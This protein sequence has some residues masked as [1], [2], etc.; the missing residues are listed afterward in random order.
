MLR[1]LIHARMAWQWDFEADPKRLPRIMRYVESD[2]C[3]RASVCYAGVDLTAVRFRLACVCSLN[4]KD[5]IVSAM[6]TKWRKLIHSAATFENRVATGRS[7]PQ[8]HE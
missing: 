8:T 5:E 7:L 2:L 6:Q 1:A 4:S 3:E